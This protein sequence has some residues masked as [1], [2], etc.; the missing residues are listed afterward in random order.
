MQRNSRS[1]GDTTEET[2][3]QRLALDL[4][5]PKKRNFDSISV[6]KRMAEL[7]SNAIS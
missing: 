4:E 5:R 1:S 2:A 7:N 6:D 3:W